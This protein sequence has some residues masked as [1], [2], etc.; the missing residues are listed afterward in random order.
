MIHVPLLRWGEPYTSL[1]TDKVGGVM[2]ELDE[3]PP[4]L[5]DDFYWGMCPWQATLP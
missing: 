1:D 5:S 4:H 3:L 2:I